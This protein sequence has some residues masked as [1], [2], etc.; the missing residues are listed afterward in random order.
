MKEKFKLHFDVISEIISSEAFIEG[1]LESLSKEILKK[2]TKIMNVRRAGVWM[3]YENFKRME[4]LVL[5]DKKKYIDNISINSE[6]YPR[7]TKALRINRSII[8]N[9][10]LEDERVAELKESYLDKIGVSSMLDT[11]IRK[12]E[13]IIGVLCFEHIGQQRNWSEEEIIFAGVLSDLL[14]QTYFLAE[15]KNTKAELITNRVQLEETNIALKNILTRFENERKTG[16]ENIANN[17][18]KNIMPVI[19]DMKVSK[20]FKPELLKQLEVSVNN[21]NSSF[22]KKLSKFNLNLS[23][24][25]IK[26]CQMINAG[27]QGKEIAE[28]LKISYSTVETHK[29][30][31]R[32][33]LKITGMSVNLK[34]YLDDLDL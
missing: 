6:D 29:K 18:E 16:K 19:N 11:G 21:L 10:V 9:N 33:K 15:I 27:Y 24:S 3:F 4:T 13:E 30:N 26:I 23:P 22:Y 34:V 2:A 25:E 20:S 7:Y 32:K 12:G 14:T 17:I 1:D 5:F 28:I 31:I 8:A